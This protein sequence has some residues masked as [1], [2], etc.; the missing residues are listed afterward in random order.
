MLIRQV[1]MG[2]VMIVS[3]WGM[4]ACGTPGMESD[5]GMR[6][7]ASATRV[8]SSPVQS[9]GGGGQGGVP[10]ASASEGAV[11]TRGQ[12][13]AGPAAA[14]GEAQAESPA[15]GEHIP[16]ETMRVYTDNT[17]AFSVQ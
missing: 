13:E 8:A 11:Q 1:L 15:P 7:P 9:S 5:G 16:L 17:H 2:G 10:A 14:S 3:M 6:V 4:T 12:S